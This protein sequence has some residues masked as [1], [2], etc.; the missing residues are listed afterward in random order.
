MCLIAFA[1]KVHP[2]YQLL[3]VA[4]RDEFYGR[5]AQRAHFWQNRPHLLAGKDLKSGGTWCGVAKNGRT[6]AVTNYRNPESF[7]ENVRSRGHLIVNYLD[8]S[9]SPAEYLRALTPEAS[10]YNAFN[11]LASDVENMYY[12]SNISRKVYRLE[13]GIYGLSN[14]LLNTP[15]YKVEHLKSKLK[16]YIEHNVSGNAALFE[17]ASNKEFA[18]DKDLPNT[19]IDKEQEKLLSAIFIETEIYGTVSTAI[20]RVSYRGKVNFVERW[21]NPEDRD[22]TQQD[23][24]FQMTK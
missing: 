2:K 1:W 8:G 15:W 21:Y 24:S 10:Q 19:G 17:M 12:F 13:S 22:L 16:Q 4:N 3:M 14:H 18:P 9:M 6:A 5:P 23:F 7:R 11:L 20:I